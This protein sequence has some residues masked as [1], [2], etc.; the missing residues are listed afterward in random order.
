M[1]SSAAYPRKFCEQILRSHSDLRSVTCQHLNWQ[2]LGAKLVLLSWALPLLHIF[3][4][5]F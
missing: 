4:R 2:S 3:N 5:P 1:K